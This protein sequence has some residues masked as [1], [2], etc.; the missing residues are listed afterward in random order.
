[1]VLMRYRCLALFADVKPGNIGC[2]PVIT[3][4]DTHYGIACTLYMID[5]NI[6]SKHVLIKHE[7]EKL[8]WDLSNCCDLPT[9]HKYDGNQTY[10]GRLFS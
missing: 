8:D 10:G 1:M 2:R 3:V 7:P 4:S 5:T 6:D 9:C